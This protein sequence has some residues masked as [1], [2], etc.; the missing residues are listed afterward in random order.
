MGVWEEG[1]RVVAERP[2]GRGAGGEAGTGTGRG[3]SGKMAE[4]PSGRLSHSP[5]RR[6]PSGSPR[7]AYS[8]AAPLGRRPQGWCAAERGGGG[9]KDITPAPILGVGRGGEGRGPGWEPSLRLPG[10]RG[11]EGAGQIPSWSL[12]PAKKAGEEEGPASENPS[13]GSHVHF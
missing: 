1:C 2:G 7:P 9:C 6:D 10:Q 13:R 11:P 5:G 4:L 3:G 8:R 12:V